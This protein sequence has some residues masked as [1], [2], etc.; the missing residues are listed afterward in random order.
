[1]QGVL[2]R[3]AGGVREIPASVIHPLK[4]SGSQLEFFEGISSVW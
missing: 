3:T 4:L 2:H 1:M